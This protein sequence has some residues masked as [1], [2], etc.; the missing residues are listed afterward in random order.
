MIVI[1]EGIKKY[2]AWGK[3]NK[4]QLGIGSKKNAYVPTP[5][6]L[7]NIEEEERFKKFV[8]GKDYSMG[9]NQEGVLY[10]W[11]DSRYLGTKEVKDNKNKESKE[12][13]NNADEPQRVQQNIKGVKD[14]FC[15]GSYA[16]IRTEE[17]FYLVG[18]FPNTDSAKGEEAKN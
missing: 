11:G 4:G 13:I 18:E 2:F 10:V 15:Y 17:K 6:S 8:C 5:L 9:L 1:C 12:R 7:S 14:I 3:N 16:V